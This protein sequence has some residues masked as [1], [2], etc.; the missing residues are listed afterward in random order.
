MKIKGKFI[1]IF[2]IILLTASFW[3][4][5]KTVPLME[6]VELFLIHT[7][8]GFIVAFIFLLLLLRF[9]RPLIELSSFICKNGDKYIFKI[10]NKSIYHA[11]DCKFELFLMEPIHHTGGHTNIKITPIS[12][13]ISNL[14]FLPRNR[15]K[16]H[17]ND[18]Y[19]QFAHT[20]FTEEDLAP[21]L[22]ANGTY[23]E[24]HI[25]AR[26]GLTGLSHTFKQ[27]FKNEAIIKENSK[28]CFG[29]NL[30]TMSINEAY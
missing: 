24:L 5:I 18:P 13:K 10:V 11:F 7:I 19:S 3:F 8:I 2:G 26:H 4:L 16:D 29:N 27:R 21:S 15:V 30:G 1:A 28:F 14:T 23:L 25:N 12:L 20:F 17:E 6:M 22:S 9:F